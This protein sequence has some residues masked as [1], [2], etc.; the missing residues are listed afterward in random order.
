MVMMRQTVDERRL[1]AQAAWEELPHGGHDHVLLQVHCARSHHVAAIFDTPQGPVYAAHV[2][3]RSHGSRDRVDEP[4]GDQ[5]ISRW[6]DF[7][8]VDDAGED[9][10]PAWCDCGHRSLSRATFVAVETHSAR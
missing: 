6:F 8:E 3:A 5:E 4:H 7:L 2:R 9:E 1:A 10:L